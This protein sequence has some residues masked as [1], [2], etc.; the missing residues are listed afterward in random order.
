[1]AW[2]L[3]GA[4]AQDHDTVV[5]ALD[6]LAK[7][8]TE[9]RGATQLVWLV[10]T[11][12]SMADD[13]KAVAE[14]IGKIFEQIPRGNKL[15]MCVAPFS[16]TVGRP[17]DFTDD[18]DA[19]KKSILALKNAGS[20]NEKPLLAVQTALE[21]FSGRGHNVIVLLTDERGDDLKRLEEV[22][23][24]ARDAAANVFAIGPEAPFQWPQRY[25]AAGDSVVAVSAGPES[26]EIEV[27]A[28]N[29]LCCAQRAP[30]G[31]A[32]C[33]PACRRLLAN[34]QTAD[35]RHRLA[36]PLGCDL[37]FEIGSGYGPWGL[38]QLARR[39]GGEFITLGGGA[40][41][42]G[43]APGSADSDLARAVLGV[44]REF[45]KGGH[46]G[47]QSAFQ[48]GVQQ[49]MSRAAAELDRKCAAWAGRL[50]KD[51]DGSKRWEANRDLVDA[52]L[53]CMR[54]YL[55]EY[56]IALDDD[57]AKFQYAQLVAGPSRGKEHREAALASLKKTAEA[58]P[59]TAWAE[60]AE[61]LK[62]NL[63]GFKLVGFNASGSGPVEAPQPPRR[64]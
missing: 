12:G 45:S 58:H 23:G 53:S 42:K 16:N 14:R 11:S 38:S 27:L 60:T 35:D 20:G 57:V 51:L 49:G 3:L 50:S 39:T 6:R 5:Q 63:G 2:W 9:L 44:V 15:T 22:A 47:L 32:T 26:A 1:M 19:I 30:F 37:L 40:P 29:P 62:K 48:V 21:W 41:A 13:R 46:F 31:F 36:N 33:Y 34:P 55:E 17:T 18:R 28:A 24:L 56:R 61:L 10:D 59:G 52:Q 54:H 64:E 4:L 25:E 7:R 8:L 43:Y